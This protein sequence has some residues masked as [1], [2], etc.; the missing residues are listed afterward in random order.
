MEVNATRSHTALGYPVGSE[1]AQK[2][3]H[4]SIS[5]EVCFVSELSMLALG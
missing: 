2:Q 5:G 3:L 1:H 4:V